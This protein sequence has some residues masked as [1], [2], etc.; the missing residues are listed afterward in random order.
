MAGVGSWD[1]AKSVTLD[2]STIA[3]LIRANA[4][5]EA[6]RLGFAPEE[7]AQLASVM[8]LPAPKWSEAAHSLSVTDIETLIRV[9]TVAEMQLSGWEAQ[10]K[11]PVV[12]LVAELKRRGAYNKELTAWIKAHTTNRFLPHGSLMDRL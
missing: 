1:P 12:P 11:S 7:I 10:A 8:R 4:E 3:R 5:I 9:L 6:P 2:S